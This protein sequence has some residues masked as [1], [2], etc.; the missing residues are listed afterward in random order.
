MDS[1]VFKE[2]DIRGIFPQQI[3][4]SFAFQL[5]Q[6]FASYLKT[7]SQVQTPFVSVGYDARLSSPKIAQHLMEG[8]Q[9]GGATVYNLGLITTPLSYYSKYIIPHLTGAIMVTG[10]H[11][12]PD[13]NGFKLSRGNHTLFGEEIQKLKDLMATDFP[14]SHIATSPIKDFDILT[15]YIKRY[16]KEFQHLQQIPVVLD[17]GN[18]AAGVVLPDLLMS[19]GLKCD[20]LY[21]QPDGH[22]PHHHPDPSV[23]ENLKDLSEK[24][25]Q[26]RAYVGIGYDGDADRMGVVDDNGCMVLGDDLMML[27]SRE[28]LKKHPGSLIIGDVK[29]SDRF[30]HSIKEHKGKAL[31]W[32]TGHSLIKKKMQEENAIF[33]G[34][35]SGH[36][37]FNDRNYG[38]DDAIYGTLRLMEI[39]SQYQKP[40]SYFFKDHLKVFTTPEIRIDMTE[41]KREQI[42]SAIKEKYAGMNMSH[43][44]INEIDGIRMSFEDGW[45]L[46]RSSN[47]QPCLV[48]RY[49]ASSQA[50]F[51]RMQSEIQTIM[52]QYL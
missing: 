5:G 36:L 7:S 14:T 32:K 25:R 40:L 28:I 24:V 39:L 35:M 19:I 48:I 44:Q 31:M 42:I 23:K 45:V 51:H 15:P 33:A 30:Y 22:F 21:E 26:T 13:Y 43:L 3:D 34:E 16:A 9:A 17:C 37:Y 27:F 52:D 41:E 2:Y 6:A 10:S 11:N 46:L 4:G 47:T 8:L 29:C 50:A 20:I 1:C 38:F 18:G 49:E 12:P